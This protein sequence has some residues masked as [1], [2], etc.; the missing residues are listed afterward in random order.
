MPRIRLVFIGG[1]LLVFALGATSGR[2]LVVNQ[3]RKSDVM[4][5][6]AGETDRRPARALQLL[7]QGYASRLILDVP[8]E[9]R[10][11]Q[12][13]QVEIARKYVEG[14]PQAGSIVVCPIYARSTRDE[15]RDVSRCLQGTR[16]ARVLLVTSDFHTRRALS[17]FNRVSPADYSVA[18][19]FDAN[20]FGVQWWRHREWA[21]T[22]MGEWIKLIWWELVDRWR[23]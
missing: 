18:A 21:K 5:V 16:A 17:I 13:N 7:D 20:E 15:A 19:A 9:A 14:L 10:I 8:A 6:L 22:N 23:P 2:F 1:G 12:W 4:V 11:Y 3:P